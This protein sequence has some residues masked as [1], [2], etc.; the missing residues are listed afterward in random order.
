MYLINNPE[1]YNQFA[2]GETFDRTA[3]QGIL[4]VN[5]SFND[6]VIEFDVYSIRPMIIPPIPFSYKNGDEIV[7]NIEW[8]YTYYMPRTAGGE[9]FDL[10]LPEN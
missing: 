4:T 8:S 9:R 5:D 10:L 2:M 7:L 3:V 1:G 6:P